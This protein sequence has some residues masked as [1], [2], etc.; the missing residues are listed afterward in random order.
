MKRLLLGIVAAILLAVTCF[1]QE[2]KPQFGDWVLMDQV[3]E[4]TSKRSTGAL[5]PSDDKKFALMLFYRN[6]P[7]HRFTLGFNVLKRGL[8]KDEGSLLVRVDEAEAYQDSWVRLESGK[9]AVFAHGEELIE[10]FMTAKIFR[11]RFEEYFEGATTVRFNISHFSEVVA[12]LK[13]KDK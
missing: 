13:K 10:K 2:T 12:A 1:A 5:L 4:M 7:A 3:D 11:I 8:I 9:I 6:D